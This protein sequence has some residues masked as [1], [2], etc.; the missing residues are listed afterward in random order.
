MNRRRFLKGGALCSGLIGA[1]GWTGGRHPDLFAQNGGQPEKP[2]A[3]DLTDAVV[4][5]PESLS[6]REQKAVQ[7]LVEEVEKRTEIRW[8]VVH[9]LEVGAHPAIVAAM[10][11]AAAGLYAVSSSFKPSSLLKSLATRPCLRSL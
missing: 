1:W 8:P 7:L 3:I 10:F 5:A 11:L 6:R 4:V 2:G 9:R